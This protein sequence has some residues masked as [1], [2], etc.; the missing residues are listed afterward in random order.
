MLESSVAIHPAY[1]KVIRARFR[2]RPNAALS[3]RTD[4]Y[5]V[6]EP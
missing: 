6:Q 5:G 4:L 2:K 1:S 3:A